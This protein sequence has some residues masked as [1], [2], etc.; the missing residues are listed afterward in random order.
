MSTNSR[1]YQHP[2]KVTHSPKTVSMRTVS[3]YFQHFLS[4]FPV[5]GLV[6]A[7][8]DPIVEGRISE[9]TRLALVAALS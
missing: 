6:I 2:S 9:L 7:T 4:G 1:E 5:G 8:K 3:R